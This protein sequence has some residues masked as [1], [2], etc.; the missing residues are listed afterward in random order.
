[1]SIR[2]DGQAFAVLV[3]RYERLVWTICWQNLRDYHA[4]QDATQE[5]FLIAHR[6]LP[7]LRQPSSFASWVSMI[8]RRESK[9]M[10]ASYEL[11]TVPDLETEVRFAEPSQGDELSVVE[12]I[13]ELPEHERIVTVLRY[14]N[15]HSVDEVAQLT[16]RPLGTVTKQLSR[17]LKR[18]KAKL[19][20]QNADLDS[21]RR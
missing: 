5:V 11:V 17:A 16:G 13:A 2:G 19:E 14:L 7:E 15:G 4:T 10:R 1:M 20:H 3:Q 21:L 18:L 6:R 12:A 8:A 9:R